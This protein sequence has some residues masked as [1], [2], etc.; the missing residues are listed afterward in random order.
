MSQTVWI[1]IVL[2]L[3]V[4]FYFWSKYGALYTTIKNNPTAVNAGLT[5]SRYIQDVQGLFSGIKAVE[6]TDDDASFTDKVSAFFGAT[7]KSI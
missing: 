7:P 6:N 4:A 1:A 2:G 5:A 3:V